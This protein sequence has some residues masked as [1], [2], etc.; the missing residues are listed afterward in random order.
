M[1]TKS[2]KRKIPLESAR[3]GAEDDSS[4]DYTVTDP[5]KNR[6]TTKRIIST[7][8]TSSA[9]RQELQTCSCGWSKV[10]STRGL[11]IHQGR[12]KCLKEARSGPRIDHYLLRERSNQASEAQR[13]ESTHSPMSISTPMTESNSSTTSENL[14]Q[15]QS[16][17]VIEDKIQ[18]RR[19]QVKW[20]KSSS[21]NK[22]ATVDADLGAILEGIRGT[23]EK[24]L[25]RM[26]DL[27]YFYG[28]ER[29]GIKEHRNE[30]P[31]PPKSRRQQEIEHLI[32]EKRNLRK[33]WKKSSPEERKGIDLLQAEL[34]GRL[35]RLRRA[36]NFQTQ[37]RK[38]EKTRTSCSTRI[39][40]NL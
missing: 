37:R 26:S 34:K 38:K 16:Q 33:R 25:E 22:W 10:T 15:N 28:A 1:A 13:P 5:G 19:P 35:G 9:A 12:M 8:L 30:T 17:P 6:T 21:K 39:P 14:G 40:S 29:F 3:A 18:G 24:K 23:A 20:P 7:A 36:E 32:K 31:T 4:T 2:P 11:K 27:I